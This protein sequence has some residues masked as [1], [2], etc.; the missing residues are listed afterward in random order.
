MVKFARTMGAIAVFAL[1]EAAF[2]VG[3]SRRSVR[4]QFDSMP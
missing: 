2:L 1:W 4:E 3:R